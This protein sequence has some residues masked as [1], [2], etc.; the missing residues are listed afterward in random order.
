MNRIGDYQSARRHGER[1]LSI[2]PENGF[3]PEVL[4]G[5]YFGLG[6]YNE[7]FNVWKRMNIELWE[8]YGV[9]ELLE[10]VF[11]EQGYLAVIKEAIRLNEEVYAKDGL[12]HEIS[13]ASRYL[14]VKNYEKALDYFEQCYETHY[15]QLAYIS[16]DHLKYPELNDNP[17][18]IALLKKMNLPL[19]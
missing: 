3:A 5:A 15:W 14:K 6:N 7:W 18:Y 1:A 8:A 12:M 11:Y 17:R 19:P 9:T 4:D 13:Q 10:K 16:L 2:D